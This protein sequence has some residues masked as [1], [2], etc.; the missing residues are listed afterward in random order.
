[1]EQPAI[2]LRGDT[3]KAMSELELAIAVGF[4]DALALY[5]D[6]PWVEDDPRLRA[7]KGRLDN[8]AVEQRS[9]LARSLEP[10]STWRPK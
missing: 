8:I 1:M 7:R 6:L 2:C 9:E 10:D 3:D 5:R 4:T